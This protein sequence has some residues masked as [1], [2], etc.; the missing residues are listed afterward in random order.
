M[1]RR[2]A[3]LSPLRSG[4]LR[5]YLPHYPVLGQDLILHPSQMRGE[6]QAGVQPPLRGGAVEKAESATEAVLGHYDGHVIA[7]VAGRNR[8]HISGPG[9]GYSLLGHVSGEFADV[10]GRDVGEDDPPLRSTWRRA[11]RTPVGPPARRRW[12]ALPRP[13]LLDARLRP[14]RGGIVGGS[15]HSSAFM[16]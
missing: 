5:S 7:T 13:A 15:P 14:R 10:F 4:L 1:S 16:G 3:P 9:L 6:W 2:S 8:Q 12:C 11:T